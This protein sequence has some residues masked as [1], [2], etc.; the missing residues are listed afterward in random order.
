MYLLVDGGV[1]KRSGKLLLS[2]EAFTTLLEQTLFAL[3]LADLDHVVLSSP[4]ALVGVD[5]DLVT[6]AANLGSGI[7]PERH[8]LVS[9]EIDKSRR[10]EGRMGIRKTLARS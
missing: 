4:A 6:V 9:L 7:W 8:G 5:G 3:A 10:K 2:L 1:L